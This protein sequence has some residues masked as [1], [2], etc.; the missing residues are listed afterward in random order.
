VH[1][2]TGQY[3]R[4]G[5]ALRLGTLSV[6]LQNLAVLCKQGGFKV[7][8]GIVGC[9]QNCFA[10]DDLSPRGSS[11][12][13]WFLAQVLAAALPDAFSGWSRHLRRSALHCSCACLPACL[14]E[15]VLSPQLL[16]AVHSVLP[17]DAS[18]FEVTAVRW[19]CCSG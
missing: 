16:P 19:C 4:P 8:I 12:Y 7:G 5:A 10:R 15:S 1:C 2:S 9:R 17:F 6:R 3:F 18:D 11:L 14:Q 13:R